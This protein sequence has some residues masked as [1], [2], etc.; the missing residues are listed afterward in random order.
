MAIDGQGGARFETKIGEAATTTTVGA[1]SL[2]DRLF[3]AATNTKT[4][5]ALGVAVLLSPGIAYAVYHGAVEIADTTCTAVNGGIADKAIPDALCRFFERLSADYVDEFDD[6]TGHPKRQDI[7]SA[8]VPIPGANAGTQE[9][10]P[11]VS[12][13][14]EVPQAQEG[15][16]SAAGMYPFGILR[17]CGLL[18]AA[19]F[20]SANGNLTDAGTQQLELEWDKIQF[21]NPTAGLN[22]S[23]IAQ[24]EIAAGVMLSCPQQ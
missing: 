7:G 10:L 20:D 21:T 24:V 5:V 14:S 9:T 11:V 4:R 13:A 16:F 12:V 3:A 15:Q 1:I 18:P 8:A 23:A 17:T 2:V 19:G 6:M 22:D